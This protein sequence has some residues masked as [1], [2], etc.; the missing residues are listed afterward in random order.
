MKK[1]LVTITLYLLFGVSVVTGCG[2]SDEQKAQDEIMSH[3]DSDEKSNIEADQQAIADY[4][5]SKQA[6]AEAIANEEPVNYVEVLEERAVNDI[7]FLSGDTPTYELNI[8]VPSDEYSYDGHKPESGQYSYGQNQK[9]LG[10]I[11]DYCDMSTN[12]LELIGSYN[13]YNIYK[14]Q[15]SN[16]VVSIVIDDSTSRLVSIGISVFDDDYLDVLDE[17]YEKNLDYIVEQLE[18][19]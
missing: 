6:E 8:L 3:M 13:D 1:K 15:L 18:A 5:E 17:I 2:K 19:L 11:V 16:K 7:S 4:K 12:G 9:D 14:N 10:I